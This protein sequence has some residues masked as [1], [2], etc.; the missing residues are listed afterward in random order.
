MMWPLLAHQG[1]WDEFLLF[2]VPAAAAIY[3]LRWAE[4]RARQRALAEA[5]DAKPHQSSSNGED[6]S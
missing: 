1:G 3:G 5:D 4:Q 6:A 2:A